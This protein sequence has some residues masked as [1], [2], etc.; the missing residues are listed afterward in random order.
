MAGGLC[1]SPCTLDVPFRFW[2]VIPMISEILITL[3]RGRSVGF[4][5]LLKLLKLVALTRFLTIFRF[6]PSETYVVKS[7]GD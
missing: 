3:V 4:Q 1:P 2:A 5:A 7:E 6:I